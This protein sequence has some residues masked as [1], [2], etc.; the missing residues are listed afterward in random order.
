MKP[1]K[2]LNQRIRKFGIKFK[3]VKNFPNQDKWLIQRDLKPIVIFR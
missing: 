1:P 3:S 2:N